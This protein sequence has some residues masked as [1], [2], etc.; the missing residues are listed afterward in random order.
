MM[1][2]S[3]QSQETRTV[4]TRPSIA[5]TIAEEILKG[6]KRLGT[7]KFARQYPKLLIAGAT[8]WCILLMKMTS[9]DRLQ[10]LPP[11][12][13]KM[14]EATI[15]RLWS[16][17]SFRARVFALKKPVVHRNVKRRWPKDNGR[18]SFRV[19]APSSSPPRPVAA[20][21]SELLCCLLSWLCWLLFSTL[22]FSPSGA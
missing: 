22:L 12:W 4:P 21:S 1:L 8:R 2:V 19:T 20:I 11:V 14:F 7:L 16:H 17:S 9:C 13:E 15:D 10:I 18:P 6:E 5:E 3:A